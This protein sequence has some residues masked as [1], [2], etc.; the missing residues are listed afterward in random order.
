MKIW[1]IDKDTGT[2]IKTGYYDPHTGL[3]DREDLLALGHTMVS[4]PIPEDPFIPK[5]N[6]KK[7]NG[8]AWIADQAVIDGR[9]VAQDVIDAKEAG[10]SAARGRLDGGVGNPNASRQDIDDLYELMQ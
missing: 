1:I 6:P 4:E 5:G 2:P 10:K 7:W 9:Q 8:G 3:T